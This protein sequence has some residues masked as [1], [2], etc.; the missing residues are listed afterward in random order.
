MYPNYK[1]CCSHLLF[2]LFITLQTLS[3]CTKHNSSENNRTVHFRHRGICVQRTRDSQFFFPPGQ[4]S[5]LFWY[6]FNQ[7]RIFKFFTSVQLEKN[8]RIL[9]VEFFKSWQ[10]LPKKIISYSFV[11]LT[12]FLFSRECQDYVHLK[13][14]G[15]SSLARRRV[16]IKE[17]WQLS[18]WVVGSYGA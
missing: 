7:R 2:V 17:K 12:F 3:M 10:Y 13:L 8:S 4:L 6:I 18:M 16:I 9:K 14:L 15:I 5:S 11:W 1:S